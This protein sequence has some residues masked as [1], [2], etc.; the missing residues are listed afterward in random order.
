MERRIRETRRVGA[1]DGVKIRSDEEQ[2]GDQGEG[3]EMGATF[4]VQSQ[5]CTGSM[6]PQRSSRDRLVDLTHAPSLHGDPRVR[7]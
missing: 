4:V 3:P 5:G 6:E 2:A 7:A 1:A